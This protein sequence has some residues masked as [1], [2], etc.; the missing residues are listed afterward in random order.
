MPSH[1]S[2]S[3]GEEACFLLPWLELEEVSSPLVIP[4]RRFAQALVL[5]GVLKAN[6]NNGWENWPACYH[7]LCVKEGVDR[8][9]N[10]NSNLRPLSVLQVSVECSS[11]ALSLAKGERYGVAFPNGYN[12]SNNTLFFTGLQVRLLN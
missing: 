5:V 11:G 3:Q 4:Q 12:T 6:W 8:G 2:C 9:V 7:V 10:P 1:Q